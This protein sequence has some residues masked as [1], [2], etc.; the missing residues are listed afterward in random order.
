MEQIAMRSRPRVP[1]VNC[2]SGASSSRLDRHLAVLAGPAVSHQESAEAT[3]LMR[4]LTSRDVSC[5]RS[6]R[7]LRGDGRSRS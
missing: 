4:E 2:G 1:A 7:R 6:S 5:A 3:S